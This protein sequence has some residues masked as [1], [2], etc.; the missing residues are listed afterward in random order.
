MFVIVGSYTF[1]LVGTTI[2]VSWQGQTVDFINCLDDNGHCAV[3]TQEQL[4][5]QA[6]FWLDEYAKV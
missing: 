5:M 1:E 6:D 4:E 2:F 3:K